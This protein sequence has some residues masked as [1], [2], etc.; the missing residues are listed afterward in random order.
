M[1]GTSTTY[2]AILENTQAEDGELKHPGPPA[3]RHPDDSLARLIQA[4][5]TVAPDET[6]EAVLDR[7]REW[8][9]L[10][11]IPVIEGDKPLGS[12]NRVNLLDRFSG[13]YTRE[14]HG[15]RPIRDFL[16]NLA[17]VFELDTSV[18]EAC[19]HLS[20]RTE[21]VLPSCAILV[22]DGC[23]RGVVPTRV[24]MRR[25]S[26]AQ[27]R[28]AQYSNP[29]TL[30]PGNVPTVELI[31]ELLDAGTEFRVAYCD[32]N[33]FK[34]F[35]DVY[36]YAIGDDALR[37]VARILVE[38]VDPGLDYIGHIGGDDFV[39]VSRS[40]DFE[41]TVRRIASSFSRRVRKLYK[42]SHVD[43]DGILAV[44]RTGKETIFPL[45]RLA[46]GVVK[47]D[48][49]LCDSHHDVATMAADAKHHAKMSAPEYLFFCRRGSARGVVEV[50]GGG[51]TDEQ[52]QLYKM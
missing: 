3:E 8:K 43:M 30:L 35:N 22:E 36:G 21:D 19:R 18:E 46:I 29:L 24:L 52:L 49:A 32:L 39:L 23:Y 13:R 47:P 12:V 51:A 4:S 17:P 31:Q 26:E 41:A 2:E 33:N 20:S 34:P 42:P 1:D 7:I 6:A 45:M 27:I 28:A 37:L 15:R 44:D 10:P 9:E 5:S 50:E 16:D 48:P 38:E 25:L 11:D 14:L 40:P